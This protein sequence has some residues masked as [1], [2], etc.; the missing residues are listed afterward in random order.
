MNG[1]GGCS[2]QAQA[3]WLGPEVGGH[4]HCFCMSLREPGELLQ[5]SKYD[6]STI[7]LNIIQVLLLLL[8]LLGC[9]PWIHH[10]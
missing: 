2:L 1:N 5:R 4:W 3:D 8:L 7:G 6:D 10:L 9:G